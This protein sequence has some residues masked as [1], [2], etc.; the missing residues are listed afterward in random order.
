MIKLLEDL[1]PISNN[2]EKSK[3]IM[4]DKWKAYIENFDMKK[5][6]L[7]A[8][9][10]RNDGLEVY[11]LDFPY[12]PN[13]RTMHVIASFLLWLGSNIGQAFLSDVECAFKHLKSK[14]KAFIS[15]W[16][17]ENDRLPGMNH[18]FR[19]TE[20]ILTPVEF[21]HQNLGMTCHANKHVTI[22]DLETID[23]LIHWLASSNGQNYLESTKEDYKRAR[24][25]EREAAFQ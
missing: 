12:T 11:F 6:N 22:E 4:I 9:H 24:Q 19:I 16:A 20:W 3:W 17:L 10:Q 21:H 5:Y 8:F 25:L 14:R 7:S 15:T 13:T 2:T 23:H 1:K 18:G